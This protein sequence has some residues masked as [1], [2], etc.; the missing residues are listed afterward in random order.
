MR[1]HHIWCQSL[2]APHDLPCQPPPTLRRAARRALKSASVVATQGSAVALPPPRGGRS[3][4]GTPR[5]GILRNSTAIQRVLPMAARRAHKSE[6]GER[7][8]G[9]SRDGGLRRNVAR[10]TR[11]S[12]RQQSPCQ[13]S[14]PRAPANRALAPA[15]GVAT[16]FATREALAEAPRPANRAVASRSAAGTLRTAPS[17]TDTRAARRR[18]RSQYGVQIATEHSA[19]RVLQLETC[20]PRTLHTPTVPQGLA[21]HPSSHGPSRRRR[22]RIWSRRCF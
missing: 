14:R 20:T 12:Q 9:A 22:L 17:A 3:P 10:G 21:A 13:A 8:R 5:S 6:C 16:D 19:T 1:L 7:R 11:R 2:T 4:S 15:A 18:F